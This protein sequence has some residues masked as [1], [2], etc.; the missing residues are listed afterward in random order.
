MKTTDKSAGSENTAPKAS[1][2][3]AA[4]PAPAKLKAPEGFALK[5]WTF[6]ST[7]D[8]GKFGIINLDTLTALRAQRLVDMKFPYLI[9]K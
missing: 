6:G 9:K 8:A 2:A 3:P 4:A 5:D 7:I 1:A